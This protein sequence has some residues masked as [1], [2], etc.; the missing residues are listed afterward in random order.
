MHNYKIFLLYTEIIDFFLLNAKSIIYN[1]SF[2]I[3][4]NISIKDD[5]LDGNLKSQDLVFNLIKTLS[6]IVKM[7][8]VVEKK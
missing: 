8:N 5:T 1:S 7:A 3:F 4:F 6:K 2:G